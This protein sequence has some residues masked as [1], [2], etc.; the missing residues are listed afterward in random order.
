MGKR[1]GF[2]LVELLVAITILALLAALLLPAVVSSREAARRAQCDNNLRQLGLAASNY[3]S[4]YPCFPPSS[5]FSEGI[6]PAFRRSHDRNWVIAIL[7]FMSAGWTQVLL[8]ALPCLSLLYP[9]RN[10]R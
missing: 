10:L 6:D 4:Q 2:S 9:T 5:Y 3:E 1:V 7:P 8:T